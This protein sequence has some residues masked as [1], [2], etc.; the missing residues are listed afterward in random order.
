[1][2]VKVTQQREPIGRIT[3][4]PRV[5]GGEPVITGTRVPVRAIVLQSRIYPEI[6]E[7]L[8]AFPMLSVNDIDEA[9]RFYHEHAVEIDQYIRENDP[10][11]N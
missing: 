5:L 11:D 2:A 4:N 8:R 10:D 9:L 6:S 1:M 7:L 3:R